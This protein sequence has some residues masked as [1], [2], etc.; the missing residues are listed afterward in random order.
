M[1]I[2][3]KVKCNYR[4]MEYGK[5]GV[6]CGY[7]FCSGYVFVLLG[8]F[9]DLF[10][11]LKVAIIGQKAGEAISLFYHTHLYILLY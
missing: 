10:S 9:L 11:N 6:F 5:T 2:I 8:K 4:D 1:Y 3:K 7:I